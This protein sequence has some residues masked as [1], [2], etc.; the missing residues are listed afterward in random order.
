MDFVG[1]YDSQAG[2]SLLR[3]GLSII[4]SRANLSISPYKQ[5]TVKTYCGLRVA[6]ILPSM[7]RY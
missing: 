6:V 3:V 5:V 1:I 7:S 2:Y 4:D